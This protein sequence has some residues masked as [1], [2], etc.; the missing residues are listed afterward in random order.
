MPISESKTRTYYGEYTLK[1]WIDLLLS[2]NI[3]LPEYQRSFAWDEGDVKK[4]IS[5]LSR[6]AFVPPITIAHDSG[7]NTIL[8]GQQ[9][10]TS[11]LLACLNRYPIKEAFPLVRQAPALE[12]EDNSTPGGNEQ[13]IPLKWTFH[14][15]IPKSSDPLSKV[16]L[17]ELRERISS[18]HEHYKELYGVTEFSLSSDGSLPE[19]YFSHYI[20]FTYIIYE[21]NPPVAGSHSPQVMTA[22]RYFAELFRSINYTGKGLSAEES[23]RALYFRNPEFT[24]FFDAKLTADRNDDVLS[25]LKVKINGETCN[26]DWIRY[27]AIL[28][29]YQVNP[30]SPLRG[31]SSLA[32]R[33][34]FFTD[35]VSW[36]VG[37]DQ[38]RNPDK[39]GN[40]ANP[41]RELFEGDPPH[42]R[43]RY[44]WLKEDIEIVAQAIDDKCFPS[45]V[46][47]DYWLFGLVNLVLFCGKRLDR[48]RW[49]ALKKKVKAAIAEV[50]TP[51]KGAETK[52]QTGV[53][54][55]PHLKGLNQLSY[56]YERLHKSIEYYNECVSI[57][58]AHVS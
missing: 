56:T 1:H 57:E 13:D 26:I 38:D 31:Y 6:G 30:S 47:A 7:I 14:K 48:S 8:D 58:E 52:G 33:E 15:L 29:A 27:L 44:V 51:A 39:F 18:D 3:V 2:G 46:D 5:A 54:R 35:Y 28:T 4:L 19:F 20:G 50:K 49:D 55:T 10:L 42:W 16:T 23:R 40:Q 53:V 17:I 37:L 36:V 22:G 45:L 41:N 21:E 34:D 32:S 9:R 12:E 11:L 24:P 25:D 43:E